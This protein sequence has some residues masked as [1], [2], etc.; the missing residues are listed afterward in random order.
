MAQGVGNSLTKQ[1][2]EAL[3]ARRDQ[4]IKHYDDRIARLGEAV[5]L[6]TQRPHLRRWSSVEPADS[7]KS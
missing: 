1:E 5:V 7:V 2:Q 4:I 3:L 6:F